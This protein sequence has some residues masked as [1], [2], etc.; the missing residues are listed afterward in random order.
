MLILRSITP[1]SSS[2]RISQ[3]HHST[4]RAANRSCIYWIFVVDRVDASY[5]IVR[6]RCYVCLG[7][8][9]TTQKLVIVTI[10]ICIILAGASADP[11]LLS[12]L[13]VSL[14]C[15]AVCHVSLYIF[16]AVLA[17]LLFNESTATHTMEEMGN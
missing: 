16:D 3:T 11:S 14:Q 15:V 6:Y 9:T 17:W 1:S 10:V 12:R 13:D 8:L 5:F 2:T 4:N 7:C